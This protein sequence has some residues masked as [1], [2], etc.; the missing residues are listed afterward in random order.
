MSMEL[1]ST[2]YRKTVTPQWVMGYAEN[3]LFMV[4]LLF[5]FF[6]I[7]KIWWICTLVLLVLRKIR[8]LV[9]NFLNCFQSSSRNHWFPRILPIR[10]VPELSYSTPTKWSKCTSISFVSFANIF[11][12]I[13]KPGF[14]SSLCPAFPF[15]VI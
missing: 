1:S 4:S 2:V 5:F 7:N 15:S 11:P 14:Y 8:V 10:I 12:F 9:Q 3:R 13:S 6:L